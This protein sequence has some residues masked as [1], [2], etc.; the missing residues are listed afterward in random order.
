[1][2]IILSIVLCTFLLIGNA[3]AEEQPKAKSDTMSQKEKL[4]YSLGNKAGSNM[5]NSS[6]DIDIETYIKA[7]REGYAGNKATMTEQEMANTIQSVQKEMKAKQAE[8]MK[9]LSEKNKKEGEAFLVENTKKEGVV[10]L[11]S[12]LQY[13]IIKEGTGKQPAKTDKV[14]VQY[15]GTFINGTEFHNTYKSDKP[16]INEVSKFIKGMAEGLQL[17][18]EGSKWILYVPSNLAYGVRGLGRGKIVGP[19]QTL[20]FEVELIS[21]E[22]K[23]E[24]K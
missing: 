12:G 11:P 8:K 18:K 13:E 7:L 21:I 4:S 1:M 16:A 20:I 24:T 17:M 19:N 23:E 2:K 3:L 6:V 22:P 9:G 15:R 14:K 5:K 10:T